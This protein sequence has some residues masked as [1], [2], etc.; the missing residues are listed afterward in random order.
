[1]G[2]TTV[3]RRLASSAISL[4]VT[5][6][7]LFASRPAAAYPW[8]IK[9]GYTGCNACHADP[10][11]GG[12]LTAYGRAQGE[13]VMRMAYN[14]APDAEP[15]KVG[16]YLF[17]VPLP[18][19][20]LLGG[21]IRTLFLHTT[22]HGAGTSRFLVMQADVGGQLT[23]GRFRVNG[24]LGFAHEGALAAA[25]TAFPENN[26][27]SRTHWIGVDI[28]SDNQVLLRAG[29]MNVP[30]GIR[31]IEHTLWNRTATAT[32]TNAN[33]QYGVSFSYNAGITRAELMAI[34]GNFSIAPDAFRSRG[35]SGYIELAPSTSVA[36]G[37]SSKVTYQERDLTLLT[38]TWRHAHGVF[39]RY[40]PVKW[41]TFLTEW[42]AL[43]TSQPTPGEFFFGGV[44]NITVDMEVL[45]GLHL[46]S[47]F[48]LINRSFTRESTSVGLWATAWWFFAPHADVRLD[49]LNQSLA[50]PVGHTAATSILAQLHFFL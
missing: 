7:C 12:L 30:F 28:G 20:L 13:I 2:S 46:A 10:S 42:N 50:T 36:V 47:T 43:H 5:L 33:Q 26:V 40:S 27:V 38:P 1:M 9:H 23:L 34:V 11:G 39:G 45:Q 29:R 48:E 37:V 18:E 16:D 19:P 6:A 21:D 8:M 49:F 25:I 4:L 14:R 32:D 15:G 17:G 3:T 31:S 41:L 24:T 22:V 44:G 35:Y